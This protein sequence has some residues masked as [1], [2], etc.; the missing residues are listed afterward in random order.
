MPS[1][2]PR[3]YYIKARIIQESEIAHAPPHVREIWDYFLRECNHIS[4]GTCERGQCVRS[5]RDIQEALSWFVGYRKEIYKKHHC[6]HAMKWLKK[7]DMIATMKTTRGMVVTVCNY[8]LYQNP[9]N[10]EYYTKPTT[11]TTMKPQ[12][13]DTINKKDKNTKKELPPIPDWL[14]ETWTDFLSHRK[15]LRKP[16]T[17]E[18]QR[19][20][21]ARVLKE[22]NSRGR[23]GLDMAMERGWQA[24]VWDHKELQTASRSGGFVQR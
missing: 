18:A 8:D 6:E 15:Q 21:L 13:T 7:A 10:Y 9:E 14:G 11:A 12:C 16:M 5:Y 1:K 2:I 17:H 3:G 19:R 22:G 24:P 4:N 20:M 23:R